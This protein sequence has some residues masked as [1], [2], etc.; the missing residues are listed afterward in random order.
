MQCYQI[1]QQKNGIC[2]EKNRIIVMKNLDETLKK[3]PNCEEGK[4][5][6]SQ[7][8]FPKTINTEK[9]MEEKTFK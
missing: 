8:A 2:I 5:L 3:T 7:H 4:I 9:N 1:K 6:Q